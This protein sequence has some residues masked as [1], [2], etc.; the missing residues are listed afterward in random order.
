MLASFCSELSLRK[1]FGGRGGEGE[2]EL[3]GELGEDGEGVV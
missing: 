3:L 1:R 2:R